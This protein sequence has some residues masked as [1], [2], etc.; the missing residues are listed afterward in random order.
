MGELVIFNIHT[1][2][3]A[4]PPHAN[5]AHTLKE[6]RAV[7]KKM[8][9]IPPLCSFKLLFGLK[10]L[11]NVKNNQIT[12]IVNSLVKKR[13]TNCHSLVVLFVLPSIHK[14]NQRQTRYIYRWV[15]YVHTYFKVLYIAVM[16]GIVQKR[17]I[18][19]ANDVQKKKKKKPPQIQ[20]KKKKKKKKK[21]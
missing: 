16:L 2:F 4:P 19:H 21:S 11:L 1:N 10:S 3:Q 6:N 18:N 17:R 9:K 7:E 20:K 13:N 14:A 5:F 15:R 8:S 12:P